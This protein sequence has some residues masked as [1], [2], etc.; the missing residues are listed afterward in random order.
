M[1]VVEER[2]NELKY[3]IE[4]F[5]QKIIG[6]DREIENI[7]ERLREMIIEMLV[8]IWIIGILGGMINKVREE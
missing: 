5:F 3:Q 4:E 1:E 8:Y 7:K 6:K 2:I